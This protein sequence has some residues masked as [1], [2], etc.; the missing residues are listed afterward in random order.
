MPI[1]LNAQTVSSLIAVCGVVCG[2]G[3]GTKYMQVCAYRLQT[4]D[5]ALSKAI[6]GMLL[7]KEVSPACGY[8]FVF[9]S[10]CG[11]SSVVC[12]W[13]AVVSCFASQ[14]EE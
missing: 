7:C 1:Y 13:D 4:A 6:C 14:P 9:V 5:A 12:V 11:L 2:L 3:G 8:V 10:S